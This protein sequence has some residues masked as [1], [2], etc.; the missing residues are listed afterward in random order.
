M[1]FESALLNSD[2]P[3]QLQ[4]ARRR[5]QALWMERLTSYPRGISGSDLP[6]LC[7]FISRACETTLLELH[8]PTRGPLPAEPAPDETLQA[9]F[10]VGRG[11]WREVALTLIDDVKDARAV[12]LA[13]ARVSDAFE[14][15]RQ[16]EAPTCRQLLRTDAEKEAGAAATERSLAIVVPFAEPA[17]PR[18]CERSYG[19]G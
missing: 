15:M 6:A 7:A 8:V 9:F 1:I 4:F 3:A 19:G 16:R 2:F 10:D 12:A 17:G 18:A 5:I 11:V 13:V 14:R